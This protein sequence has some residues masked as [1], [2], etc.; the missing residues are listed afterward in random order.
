MEFCVGQSGIAADYFTSAFF[1][2]QIST[3]VSGPV[4]FCVAVRTIRE[5]CG[6]K[7]GPQ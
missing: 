5:K 3:I 4:A 2:P 7:H 1:L 6:M